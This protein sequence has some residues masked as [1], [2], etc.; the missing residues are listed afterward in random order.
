M[1]IELNASYHHV[2]SRNMELRDGP[3]NENDSKIENNAKHK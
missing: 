2:G 1:C 3:A